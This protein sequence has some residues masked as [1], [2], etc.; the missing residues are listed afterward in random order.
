MF[1]AIALLFEDLAPTAQ[2][3]LPPLDTTTAL[4]GVIWT[5][6]GDIDMKVRWRATHAVL[7]LVRLGCTAE[8]DILAKFA[9]G[10]E[11]SEPFLDARYPFY[12]LHARMWL[13]LALAR[14][15]KEPKAVTLAGFT[16]WLA[17]V[18]RGPH[19]AVN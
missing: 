17:N 11:S 4:T 8:L 7:L 6:L 12:A 9:R 5:A 19:H 18:I 13:L 14:A 3:T 16:S 2:Q 1:D 10:D 15:A